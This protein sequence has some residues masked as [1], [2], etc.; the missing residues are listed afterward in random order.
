MAFPDSECTV[1]KA[2][3]VRGE[4]VSFTYCGTESSSK[5]IAKILF[6]DE[7]KKI[8]P[9]VKLGNACLSAKACEGSSVVKSSIR[10]AP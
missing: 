2:C 5:L 7:R 9:F 3:N 10:T 8:I 6:G 4:G 1:K